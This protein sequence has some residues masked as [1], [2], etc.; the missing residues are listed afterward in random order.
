M[1][2]RERERERERPRDRENS[3]FGVN[4]GKF[5]VGKKQENELETAM[6]RELG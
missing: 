5:T 6:R 2:E 4:N 3:G 1:V